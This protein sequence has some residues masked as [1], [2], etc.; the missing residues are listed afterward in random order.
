MSRCPHCGAQLASAT[1]FCPQCGGAVHV[2][3]TEGGADDPALTRP[4]GTVSA[5]RT[6]TAAPTRPLPEPTV[7]RPSGAGRPHLDVTMLLRGNWLGAGL[8]AGLTVLTAGLLALAMTA[9]AKPT[10]FGLDNSLTLVASILNGSFGAD[11]VAHMNLGGNS[12]EG[13]LGA[14]PLTVT[15]I[16]L[17]VAVVAFRRVTAGYVDLQDA[18]LDAARAALVLGLALMTIAIVFRADSREF[19][20]GWGNLLAHLFDARIRFG[21]SI[22]GSFAL[23]FATVL[24]TLLGSL[25]TRRTLWPARFQRAST[26]LIPPMY[27]LGTLL[28]LLPV[29]GLVGLGLMLATG[30]TVQDAT[31]SSHDTLATCALIFGVLASGGFWLISVGAGSSFGEHGSA[32]GSP[33]SATYQHLKTFADQDPGLWAAPVVL[34]AVIGLAT[35]VVARKAPSR[36]SIQSSLLAWTGTML[37]ATP[38]LVR[39]TSVHGSLSAPDGTA[40]GAVGVNGWLT[41]LLLTVVTLLFSVVV[42]WRCGVLDTTRLREAGRRLQTNPGQAVPPGSDVVER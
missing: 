42:A 28:L 37:V 2:D 18:V 36:E 5:G 32:T 27:G 35:Y 22:A 30:H 33:D 31:T 40:S 12:V 7:G 17:L 19:G 39:L 11:L 29:A 24:V 20:R 6:E 38:L 13:S 14:F 26:F 23:G 16:A 3:S 8:V 21:P 10:D 25:W 4:I 15:I 1:P 34:L 9:L 41:T